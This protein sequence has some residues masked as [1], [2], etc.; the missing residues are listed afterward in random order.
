MSNNKRIN[1]T[2]VEWAALFED[3]N[4][5]G[6]SQSVFCGQR[7]VNY[8]S[9]RRRYRR[10]PQFAGKRRKTPKKAFAELAMPESGLVMHLDERVR[11]DC[12]PGMS[13]EAIATLAR[14]LSHYAR[15]AQTAPTGD[16]T[17]KKLR[18][19]S[20]LWATTPTRSLG[21]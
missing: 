19:T 9:F 11:I 13:P 15:A 6:L 17:E 16:R 3:F 4:T 2:D 7:G 8:H 18:H 14:S 20:S 10:S 1:R 12:P 5:S 21:K